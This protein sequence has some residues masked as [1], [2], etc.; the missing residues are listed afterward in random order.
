MKR[1]YYVAIVFRNQFLDLLIQVGN[2]LEQLNEIICDQFRLTVGKKNFKRVHCQLEGLEI[3]EDQ[4]KFIGKLQGYVGLGQIDY[5]VYLTC[6]PVKPIRLNGEIIIPTPFKEA[7]FFVT[8]NEIRNIPNKP[9]YKKCEVSLKLIG[10]S[11]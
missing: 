6:C 8:S 10:V 11:R 9:I 1:N 2:N 5:D 7:T 3:I 4:W